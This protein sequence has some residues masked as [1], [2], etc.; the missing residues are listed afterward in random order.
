MWLD[1]FGIRIYEGYGVTETS[2][3]I[4]VNTPV[5]N[6]RGTVGLPLP[7]IEFYLEPV[8]GIEDGGKLVTK[9]PNIML[10]YLLHDQPGIVIPPETS[11]GRGWYDTGD[12]ASIDD[13]GYISIIGRAKRFA[14]LG[15]EMIS[16][17]AVEELATETWPGYNHAV[18]SLPD[19]RKGE[20]IVLITDHKG[21][22]RKEIQGLAKSLKYGELYVPKKVVLAE[23]L[24]LLST[25]KIDYITLTKMAL[26]EDREGSGWVSLITK[27]IKKSNDEE[28]NVVEDNINKEQEDTLIPPN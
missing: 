28:L 13:E 2:P 18:V 21:A 5:I 23:E 24:P 6:R 10:G 27:F 1:K 12:I 17:T 19:D 8:E 4:S 16:L 20:K 26:E 7:G 25:G 14:K 11:R 3:V 15:G 9:G 22:S